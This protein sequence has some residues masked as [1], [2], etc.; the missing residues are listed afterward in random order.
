MSFQIQ[1]IKEDIVLLNVKIMRDGNQNNLILSY[2]V[3]KI[4]QRFSMLDKALVSTPMKPGIKFAKN[5]GQSISQL[6]YKKVIGSLMYAM[7]FTRPN[8]AF[9]LV[10][11]IDLQAIQV[12]II[13][14]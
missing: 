9:R 3:E 2:Y 6:E 10:K 14:L 5:I 11:S 7:T 13:E 4:L 1:D 12:P 8:I